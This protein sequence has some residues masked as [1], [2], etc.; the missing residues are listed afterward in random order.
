MDTIN[1]DRPNQRSM[2]CIFCKQDSSTSITIEHI[3]PEALGNK[4][5]T[6][7]PGLVCDNCNSYF[8]LKVEKPLLDSGYFRQ[9]RSR[10]LIYNKENRVPTTNGILLPGIIPVEMMWDKEGRSV[11]P[12]R[13]RDIGKLINVL[14]NTQGGEIIVPILEKPS[15]QLMSRF[16]AKMALEVLASRF[17][18]SSGELNEVIDKSELDEFRHYAR[19]GSP[20]KSWPYYIRRLYPEGKIFTE[21]ADGF[22]VLHEY[23]LLYTESRELYLVV[24]IFE[25]EYAINMGGPE[26]DGYI[27]WLKRHDNKSVLE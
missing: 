9:A 7:P 2:R 19:F 4:E 12:S 5:H 11:F 3:I 27:E 15:E 10:N 16:L 25:M 17:L 13:E 23:N 1:N 8:G 26:I 22:E 6:L 21:E 24:I 20:P 14:H 18:A